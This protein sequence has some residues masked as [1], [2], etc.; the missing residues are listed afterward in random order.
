MEPPL[1]IDLTQELGG[2]CTVPNTYSVR[3]DVIDTIYAVM[4]TEAQGRDP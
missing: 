2:A 1:W 4:A 3:V